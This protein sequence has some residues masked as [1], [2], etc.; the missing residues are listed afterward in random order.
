MSPRR[1]VFGR[2]IAGSAVARDE[3][4]CLQCAEADAS[5]TRRG[6]VESEALEGHGSLR[7]EQLRLHRLV[8]RETSEHR[9]VVERHAGSVRARKGATRL[10]DTLQDTETP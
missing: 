2:G 8:A 9:A 1:R 3:A 5:V 7:E 6:V 4:C 10:L